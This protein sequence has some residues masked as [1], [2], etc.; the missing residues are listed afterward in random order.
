MDAGMNRDWSPEEQARLVEL[1]ER[2][3]SALQ[4]G[5]LL[6]R[7]KNSVIGRC[8]R[9]GVALLCLQGTG[10]RNVSRETTGREHGEREARP[11]GAA[12][13]MVEASQ[14]LEA[15]V[16]EETAQGRPPRTSAVG[17]KQE[18]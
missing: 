10:K 2:R 3:M 4:I 16:L 18:E 15:G 13:A 7:S 1:A 12:A 6:G 14:G 9:T 8:R 5:L 11:V 17:G